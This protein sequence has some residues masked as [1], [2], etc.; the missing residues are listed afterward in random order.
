VLSGFLP[1]L[2]YIHR[3]DSRPVNR[4]PRSDCELIFV[5]ATETPKDV[6]S[7][8]EITINFLPYHSLLI[9]LVAVIR[10]CFAEKASRV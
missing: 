2:L 10:G 1:N 3:V 6:T 4:S 7:M 5:E 8:T 9:G